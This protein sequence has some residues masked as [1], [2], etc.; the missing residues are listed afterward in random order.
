MIK[1]KHKEYAYT[2]RRLM[3]CREDIGLVMP[4]ITNGAK[5]SFVYE[6]YIS[7]SKSIPKSWLDKMEPFLSRCSADKLSL[8]LSKLDEDI[9]LSPYMIEYNTEQ[10]Y[11]I[12]KGL[13]KGYDITKHTNKR[14]DPETM[15]FILNGLQRGYDVTL[16]NSPKLTHTQMVCIYRGLGEGIDV[17]KFNDSKYSTTRMGLIKGGL[18]NGLDISQYND[19]NKYSDRQAHVIYMGLAEGVDITK[20]NDPKVASSDMSAILDTMLTKSKCDNRTELV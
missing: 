9:D 19:P 15:S 11:A 14:T 1:F 4:H 17:T 16:Y 20:F 5:F 10:L 18:R 13:K 6:T 2:L 3:K 8:M 7:N 12:A